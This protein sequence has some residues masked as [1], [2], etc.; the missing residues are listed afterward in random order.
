[1]STLVRCNRH[2][3]PY[4]RAIDEAERDAIVAAIPDGYYLS[5]AYTTRPNYDWSVLLVQD[6]PHGEP[7]SHEKGRDL[8]VTCRLALAR[9]A[10]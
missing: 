9:R 4:W 8:A 7:V 2:A 5:V 6:V 10:A 3:A 1:M